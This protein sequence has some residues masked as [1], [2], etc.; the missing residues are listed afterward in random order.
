MPADIVP[1]AERFQ[2]A[3]NAPAVMYCSSMALNS[4]EKQ[5][6]VEKNQKSIS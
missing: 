3:Y 2:K 1:L 6:K 5:S 4:K